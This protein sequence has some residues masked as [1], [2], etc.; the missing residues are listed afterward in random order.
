MSIK[1]ADVARTVLSWRLLRLAMVGALSW[2][3]CC[4]A[5]FFEVTDDMDMRSLQR[6]KVEIQTDWILRDDRG[7]SHPLPALLALLAGVSDT[8]SISKGSLQGG[9]SY[10]HAWGLL[11]QFADQFGTRLVDKERGHGTALTPLAEKLIW[12]DRRVQARL[13]PLLDSLAS[14][15]QQELMRTV[16]GSPGS[17]RLTASHGFAVASLVTQL[18]ALGSLVDIQYRSSTDA[19]AALVRGE[20]DLAG[21]HL[22]IGKFEAAAAAKYRPWLDSGQHVFLHLAYR[23]QGLFV[24]RGNPKGITGVSELTRPDLRLVNRQPGSGTR[25]LFDLLLGEGHV[26]RSAISG[27][28]SAEYT[29]AAVAA[30]VA[31]GMAD[32]GFGVEA[33]ARRFGLDFIPICRE[34]YFLACDR[35]ALTLPMLVTAIEAMTHPVF[36]AALEK[37]P[38]YDGA[39]AGMEVDLSRLF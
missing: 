3:G 12:A 20:C 34:R 10:R 11:E 28:D 33:A 5:M 25:L 22:P 29:H 19:V 36:R 24:A 13:A 1:A 9:M 21:F 38:G 39:F 2:H 18:H 8:G 6:F 4:H 26:D 14:E 7:R 30:F 27:Y 17:L 31:S 35:A 23:R 16:A 37:L 32:V 15:L